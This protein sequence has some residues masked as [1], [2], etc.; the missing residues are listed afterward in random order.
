MQN[1]DVFP[2]AFNGVGLCLTAHHNAE[3]V[4]S[5]SKQQCIE[6]KTRKSSPSVQLLSGVL[7]LEDVASES[8]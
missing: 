1:A 4:S 2:I 6:I 8:I 5:E 7:W 3:I